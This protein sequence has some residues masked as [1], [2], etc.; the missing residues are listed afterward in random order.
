MTLRSH[1]L[2]AIRRLVDPP[3]ASELTDLTLLERF[4]NQDDDGAFALLVRRHGPMV[5]SVC[6]RVL[7][8]LH[9]AEDAFQATVLVLARKAGLVRWHESVG[10][11]L[12]LVA[13]H[14]A[15]KMK[16]QAKRRR[17]DTASLDDI[18]TPEGDAASGELRTILDEEL[19]RFPETYRAVV[20]LCHCQGRSRAEAA[21][22]L[23][24]KPGTVKIRLERTGKAYRKR[25]RESFCVTRRQPS[26]LLPSCRDDCARPR[27][28][29][30]ITSSSLRRPR[31]PLRQARRQQR[32]PAH[33]NPRCAPEQAAQR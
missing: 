9:D 16:A 13:F 4:A 5:L 30:S 2:K 18:A 29:M 27:V 10:G 14:L 25:G 21:Q 15:L 28:S 17:S 3:G 1:V 6:R 32:D 20:V 12:F 7:G 22:Q 33:E 26:A 11:W 23:G 8:S 31:Y 24:W 19:A